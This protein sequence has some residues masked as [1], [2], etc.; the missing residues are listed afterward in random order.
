MQRI[1]LVLAVCLFTQGASAQGVKD[2][3]SPNTGMVYPVNPPS[4]PS[5]PTATRNMPPA[6]AAPPLGVQ[7]VQRY[8]SRS[9]FRR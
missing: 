6:S 5:R 8:G 3:S 2:P 1:F 7:R 4:Q 9:R